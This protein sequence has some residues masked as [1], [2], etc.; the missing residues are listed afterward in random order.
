MN[1]LATGQKYTDFSEN[2]LTFKANGNQ[3]PLRSAE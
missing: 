2:I 1:F 3:V